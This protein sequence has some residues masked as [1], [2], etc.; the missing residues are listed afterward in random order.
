MDPLVGWLPGLWGVATDHAMLQS[1]LLTT[2]R[3]LS[4]CLGPM[5]V[6]LYGFTDPVLKYV[7]TQVTCQ[8]YVHDR[9]AC[10]HNSFDFNIL[11]IFGY[12][13]YHN[14]P[15]YHV[16][17]EL[18]HPCDQLGSIRRYSIHFIESVG[19]FPVLFKFIP[20]LT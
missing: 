20:S 7:L 8:S 3:K 5:S 14:R 18:N 10:R 2:A 19:N 6:K 1:Q 13:I 4:R 9:M 11:V 17:D 16:F 15:C 12:F